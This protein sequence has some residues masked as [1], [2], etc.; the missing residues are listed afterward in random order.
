MPEGRNSSTGTDPVLPLIRGGLTRLF[1]ERL[2]RAVLFGSRARGDARDDSDY[3]VM[4]FLDEYR[5]LW[6]ELQPL[7]DL[8]TEIL[9][10]TGAVVNFLPARAEDYSLRTGFMHDVRTEGRPV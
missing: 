8:A 6:D 1:G 2:K 4:V 5:G 10:R 3:D 9:D 7:G